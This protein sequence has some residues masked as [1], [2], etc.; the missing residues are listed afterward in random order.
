[1]KHPEPVFDP[2]VIEALNRAKDL[3]SIPAV[4]LEVLRVAQDEEAGAEDLA[5]VVCLDPVLAARVLKAAN[6][7]LFC[8][9]GEITTLRRACSRLDSGPSS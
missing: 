3:P 6:S 1:M 5:S 8:G 7:V 2:R 4:A 9:V